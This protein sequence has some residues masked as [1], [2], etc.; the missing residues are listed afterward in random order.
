MNTSRSNR[1]A[2]ISAAVAVILLWIGTTYGNV[3]PPPEVAA[4]FTALV[5]FVV[6]AVVKD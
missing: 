5:G 3:T 4:A 2:G 1:A 6:S